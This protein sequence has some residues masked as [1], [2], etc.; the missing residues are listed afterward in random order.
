MIDKYIKKATMQ[1]EKVSDSVSGQIAQPQ[2][3]AGGV[4]GFK[5]ESELRLKK[6]GFI[7][8]GCGKVMNNRR[9]KTKVY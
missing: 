4:E 1:A 7:A 8:K 2:K 6:G 5:K 3:V 9:K